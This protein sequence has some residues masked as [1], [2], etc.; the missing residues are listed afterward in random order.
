MVDFNINLEQ[1]SEISSIEDEK[2]KETITKFPK[3]DLEEYIFNKIKESYMLNSSTDDDNEP[4]ESLDEIQEAIED[5]G[6]TDEVED[7]EY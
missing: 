5:E 7:N 4:E 2:L 3:K 1:L 6:F